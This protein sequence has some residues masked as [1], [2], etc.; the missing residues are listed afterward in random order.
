MKK[1]AYRNEIARRALEA[2]AADSGGIFT[3]RKLASVFEIV[4]SQANVFT[5]IIRHGAKV[6]NWSVSPQAEGK[7]FGSLVVEPSSFALLKNYYDQPHAQGI[8]NPSTDIVKY[9]LDGTLRLVNIDS[10]NY[11]HLAKNFTTMI[12]PALT[13]EQVFSVSAGAAV[14]N[15]FAKF[16]FNQESEFAGIIRQDARY[17]R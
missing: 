7:T 13:T 2:Y 17:S 4:P 9:I 16:R 12:S 8:P 5:L 3:E 6:N 1:R 14:S 10:Q 11:A 15:A